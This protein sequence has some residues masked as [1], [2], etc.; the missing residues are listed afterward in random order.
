[1]KIVHKHVWLTIILII[2]LI[3]LAIK[4]WGMN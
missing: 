3:S 4:V 2:A 1:M